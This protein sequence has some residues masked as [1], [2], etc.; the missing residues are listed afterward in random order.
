MDFINADAYILQRQL[1][2]PNVGCL[3]GCAAL[4]E[5]FNEAN[6]ADGSFLSAH[7]VKVIPGLKELKA[8]F[9][10][11][12]VDRALGAACT[13]AYQCPGPEAGPCPLEQPQAAKQA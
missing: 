2:R 3:L 10:S 4:Q 9:L 1:R 7:Q 8:L 5:K 11:E 13:M 6:I 12:R